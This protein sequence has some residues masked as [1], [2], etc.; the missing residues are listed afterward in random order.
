MKLLLDTCIF[1]WLT[2]KPAEL[3]RAARALPAARCLFSELE[4]AR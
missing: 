4:S 2:Q 1:I 3:S